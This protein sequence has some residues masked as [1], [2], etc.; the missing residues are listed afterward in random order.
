M[1]LTNHKAILL[2]ALSLLSALESRSQQPDWLVAWTVNWSLNP[3]YP[4]HRLA[5][6]DNGQL[7]ASRLVDARLN[8]GLD[9]FGSVALER[10]DPGTGQALWSCTLGDSAVMDALAVGDDGTLYAAGRFMGSLNMCAGPVMPNHGSGLDQGISLLAIDMNGSLL[11][12][13]DLSIAHPDAEDIGAM[14]VDPSGGVWVALENFGVADLVRF[15]GNGDETE[16]RTIDGSK[17][18]G[19]MD[20]APSGA[21]YVS[22][23]TG[24]GPFTFG[25]LS[26][27]APNPYNMYVLR[28]D[29][30]G[31]GDWVAFASDITFQRPRV[32][33]D[34]I[35][36][37][38]V[39]GS[40]F[41]STSFGNVQFHGPDW[42]YDLFV[43][44]ADSTGNFLW[45]KESAPA[46]G[47]ITG[48]M[49][50]GDGQALAADD[51]GNSYLI[52]NVRGEVD[53][54]A[55]VI[56]SGQPISSYCLGLV[57]FDP[58][59]APRWA[60]TSQSANGY[61]QAQALTSDPGGEVHFIANADGTLDF[62]PLSAGATG[63]QS[64]VL[65]RISAVP[66]A[67][68]AE[69]GDPL[70]L[71]EVAPN[72][73]KGPFDLLVPKAIGPV[74]VRVLDTFG[75]IVMDGIS[76]RTFGA[77]LAP[78]AYFVDV[79]WSAGHAIRRIVKQ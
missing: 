24:N 78:G 72:I 27:N 57:S 73:G 55:G 56:N 59:G 67:V 51:A 17:L 1:F 41:A 20:F 42:V 28:Y 74:R 8:Y 7:Y 48:D 47:P 4:Q 69:N 10:I 31:N 25:G 44:K 14:A 32:T 30:E 38:I 9:L 2:T 3:A 5:R 60:I 68:G 37:A 71:L 35:G 61:I 49:S 54:G 45:G 58:S 12:S 52:G 76:G 79:N 50:M 64:A 29:A 23:A 66:T 34:P 22:G 63:Q 43:T 39:A 75:R 16:S 26:S 70:D 19:G 65:G 46:G 53:W 40:V 77:D 33:C 13:M 11:W 6:G 21:L 62:P 36:N 15:D 18:V